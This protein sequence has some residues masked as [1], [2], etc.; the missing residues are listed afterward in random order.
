VI[1]RIACDPNL[2]T[3]G[4]YLI[5]FG[6]AP[7]RIIRPFGVY[8]RVQ[9]VQHARHVRFIE[10]NNMI[11]TTQRRDE[12]HAFVL[13]KNRPPLILDEAHGFVA[14]DGDHE[15]ISQ[16]PCMFEVSQMPNVENVEAAVREND[17]LPFET[18]R[19]VFKAPNF[20][21]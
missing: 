19:Q 1:F 5:A 8:G 15:Y 21:F 6:Y 14:V 20:Y 10:D 9:Y 16:G 13:G 11:N 12:R 18:R 4:Q 7:L 3:I 2:A 17:F